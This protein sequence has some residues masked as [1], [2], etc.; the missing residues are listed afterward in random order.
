MRQK[1]L[2]DGVWDF[3]YSSEEFI[4]IPESF[5]ES[6]PVPSCYD[7]VEPY[8]GVR[9]CGVYRRFVE[10]GGM[11]RL[12]IEG[13][14]ITAR[15]YWDRR[16]IKECPYTYM[17][18]E[19]IFDAGD[20][21]CH[22]L[23]IAVDNRHNEQFRPNFDFYGYGGIYGSIFI[24][25][26][27]NPWIE[28]ILVSTEDYTCGKIRIQA[29][30]AGKN[31]HEAVLIFDQKEAVNVC[32]EK[33][34]LDIQLNVPNYRLWSPEEPNLH[35]LT[36]KAA[37]DQRSVVFG[38]RAFST[39]GR[40]IL[41]NGKPIKLFG[42]NRHESHPE[43]GAATPLQ[44]IAA[45]LRMIKAQ[46]CNFIRGSHYPQR[47]SFLDLCDRMGIMVWEETMSW[48]TRAP[49][50]HSKEFI[51]AQIEQARKLTYASFN[52]PC[53][54]IRGFM[55]ENDSSL[56]ETRK[57]VKTLY[58]T[59]RSID[60]HCLISFASNRYE[61]DVCTDL[62]DVVGMNPYPGW[63]DSSFDSISTVDKVFPRL[64][65]LSAA[66]PQD[67]PFLI[68]EIGCEALLGFRDRL[69]A[70]WTEEYQAKVLLEVCRYVFSGDEC[71]GVAIWHFAD[72]R[73]FVNGPGIYVRARGFN[74]KGVLDEYRHPKLAWNSIAEFLQN[75]TK[76]DQENIDHTYESVIGAKF[77]GGLSNVPAETR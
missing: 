1:M 64:Q 14:G 48:G 61:Q 37:N 33:G 62:V 56:P 65:K 5:T 51:D 43:M 18:E 39:H 13:L 36:I 7:L 28:Q 50:L 31:D 53:I 9:G 27:P 70:R 4:G 3:H 2:L 67:R 22:E 55:N 11:A 6:L 21:G 42:Y 30:I 57:V 40:Q 23:V 16:I 35:E 72:C 60:K 41:L 77:T 24:E 20:E 10:C 34:G 58:E 63:Y 71:A 8:C 49:E 26:L 75:V 15:I 59:I 12:C 38:I 68:T 46:G 52:H 54:A 32:F 45:D 47:R 66:L 29:S 17:P 76:D 69:Q 19:I 74:N 73:S 44:L 25:R